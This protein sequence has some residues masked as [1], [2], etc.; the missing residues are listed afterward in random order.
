[1]ATEVKWFLEGKIIHVIVEG[2]LSVQDVQAVSDGVRTHIDESDEPLVHLV[3]SEEK[4]D[5]LPKSL[6]SFSSAAEFVRHERLGW[7]LIYGNVERERIAVFLA[8]IVISIAKVRHRRFHTLEE[9]LE[10]LT[11][12]DTKLPPI[13]EMRAG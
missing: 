2:D 3:L 8:T 10:F 11:T 5:S 6:K 12:V 13:D 7:F 9:S 4:M 1:M